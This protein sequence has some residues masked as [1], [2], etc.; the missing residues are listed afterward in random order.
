M[1]SHEL[2]VEDITVVYARSRNSKGGVL[3][4]MKAQGGGEGGETITFRNIVVE[5]KRP[6]TQH[7][8]IA[9][10]GV[11][12]WVNPEKK[13]DPGDLHGITFQVRSP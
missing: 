6:T 12:P 13:R 5:D 8:V 7:F 11:D 1:N 2:I 4:N 9:M 10:E 3:F